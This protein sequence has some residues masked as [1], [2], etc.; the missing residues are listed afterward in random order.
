MSLEE[1]NKKKKI[2]LNNNGLIERGIRNG[3]FG[4]FTSYWDDK[5]SDIR[6]MA[7]KRVED[8]VKQM[9]KD[10][11]H[12]KTNEEKYQYLSDLNYCINGMLTGIHTAQG[13]NSNQARYPKDFEKLEGYTSENYT[14]I[15]DHFRKQWH[16]IH[17]DNR[18]EIKD[19]ITGKKL[20]YYTYSSHP[21]YQITA[22][23]LIEL[24][25]MLDTIGWTF[26]INS[27]SDHFPSHTIH[28]EYFKK[29]NKNN[30]RNKKT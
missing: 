8:F 9:D 19:K 22:E 12:L 13:Y 11:I 5:I 14:S 20:P 29:E 7:K 30:R 15:F 24:A 26:Q 17:Y 16:N 2:R 21:Y 28:I 27:Y 4:L 3:G 25:K 6:K 10:I 23:K 1:Q 18:D